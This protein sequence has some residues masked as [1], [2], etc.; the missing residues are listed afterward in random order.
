M[1]IYRR[2]VHIEI[3]SVTTD[4]AFALPTPIREGYRFMGWYD[5]AEL[6]GNPVSSPYS[7]KTVHTLYAKWISEEE[8][9]ALCDGTSFE[10]AY[11]ITTG[12]TVDAVID[13]AGKYVY[14]VFT[15]IESKTYTF[16]SNG[17]YDTYG[18][19]YNSNQS[20]LSS[21]D[22]GGDGSNFLISR[23]MS[24]GEVVYLK[25]KLYS[26]SSIGTFTVTVS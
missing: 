6:S 3:E 11:I 24:A 19:L 17:S 7:S 20:Q 9:L 13:T 12:Q 14:F 21:N 10:K 18:Y 23:S 5:N 25:V 4:R 1:G 22:D 8:Y 26:S 16:Q 15:A 2:R